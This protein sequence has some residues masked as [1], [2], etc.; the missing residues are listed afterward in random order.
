MPKIKSGDSGM[1]TSAP[2]VMTAAGSSVLPVARIIAA[3]ELNSHSGMAAEK[4]ISE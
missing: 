4:T 1:S 3:I 2:T